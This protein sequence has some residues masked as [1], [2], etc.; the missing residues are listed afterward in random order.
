[1]SQYPPSEIAHGS[2][3]VAAAPA[4]N[5][6]RRS[7]LVACLLD[8]DDLERRRNELRAADVVEVRADRTG[9]L[10]VAS[11]RERFGG[12]LLYTLRSVAEGGAFE[13]DGAERRRRLET[14]AA[15]YD[16]VDL[17]L[18]T[19][20]GDA[21]LLETVPRERRV[22]SWHGRFGEPKTREQLETVV[23]RQLQVEA[24]QRK[25]VA[26]AETT[27]EALC[28]VEVLRSVQ[29]RGVAGDGFTCFAMGDAGSWTR[30][31]CARLGSGLTFTA[32]GDQA[33]SGQMS[34]GR[35]VQDYALD[36]ALPAPTRLFGVVGWPVAHSLSPR[37]HNGAYLESGLASSMFLPFAT[38]DFDDFWALLESGRFEALGLELGGFAVT[39]PHKESAA[40]RADAE[41]AVVAGLG[42]GNTLTPKD[43]GWHV[44]STDPEGVVGPLRS[45]HL[46]ESA[47]SGEHSVRAAVLG[48][49]GAGRAAVVGL[50]GAGAE[51]VLVNRTEETGR[52]VAERLATG[53]TTLDDFDPEPYDVIVNATA[54]G[55]DDSDPMPFDCERTRAAVVDMV[56]RAEGSTD[57]IEAARRRGLVT[58]DGREVLLHQALRQFQRMTGRT[59]NGATAA[60]R[61][62][63]PWTD[64][65]AEE[66]R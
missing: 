64:S 18:E 22:V 16:L 31:L 49:G 4:E 33:A 32:L 58:I 56:Y 43:G 28:A 57:L 47:Q 34:L 7:A 44:D 17:E 54:L 14:A 1:M 23:D 65:P 10:D 45:R 40:R 2:E 30:P 53:F 39:T 24:S 55:H 27:E 19:D 62:G 37:L 25:V 21:A 26:A 46:I 13:G 36:R 3:R 51:V 48:A 52:R 66:A 61:L 63:A 15:E 8:P 60:R 20:T 35:L 41:S 9:D 12:R 11:L 50:R 59:M 6:A 42:A 5:G 38:D 29:E